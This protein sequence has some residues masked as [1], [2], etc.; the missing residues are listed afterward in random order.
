LKIL[1]FGD[2]HVWSHRFDWSDCR[3]LKRWTG[4]ANLML[5]RRRR[6]PPGLGRKV[7]TEIARSDADVVIFTGDYTTGASEEEFRTAAELVRPL[8]DKWGDRFI[9]LP[10]NH[11]RYTPK[12][13][14]RFEEWFHSRLRDGVASWDTGEDMA[15]VA[16]DASKPYAFRSNGYFSPELAGRLDRELASRA[17][18][19]IIL[20]GHYPYATP[21]EHQE[22]IIH[23]LIGAERLA[24][25]VARHRPMVYLHGHKHV[26]WELRPEQ[27]PETLCLNC[28]SAGMKSETPEKQAGYLTFVIEAAGISS[29]AFERAG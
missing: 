1:H 5:K 2:L 17:G 10:G 29:V 26:R 13:R 22:N 3:Y 7:I 8:R 28:G 25:L 23:R 4:Y 27:T 21:P 24:E 6:F 15:V 14:D 11:D 9:E 18:K 19:K 12:S 16:Y 20:A